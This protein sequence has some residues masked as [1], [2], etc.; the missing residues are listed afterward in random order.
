MVSQERDIV[1][2]ARTDDEGRKGRVRAVRIAMF[3]SGARLDLK[4]VKEGLRFGSLSA[5]TVSFRA[6]KQHNLY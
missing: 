6:S 5:S 2:L 1:R 4:Q 3:E